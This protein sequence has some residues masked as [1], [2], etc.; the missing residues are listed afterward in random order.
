MRDQAPRP[1]DIA[2]LRLKHDHR[3]LKINVALTSA[4]GREDSVNEQYGRM[5]WLVT[6][7]TAVA[8]LIFSPP[9]NQIRYS[10]ETYFRFSR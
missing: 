1:A 9:G 6:P 4:P 8:D 2:A 3:T 10:K 5:S 7:V